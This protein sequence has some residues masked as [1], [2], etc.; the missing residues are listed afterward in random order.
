MNDTYITFQGWVGSDVS[1]H[2]VSEDVRVTSFRVGSTPRRLREG[3]WEDQA[4]A[5]YTV[6]AWRTLGAHVATSVRKGDPVVV[7]GR[8][9]VEEWPGEEG[10]TMSRQVVHALTVGHDLTRG[11][12]RFTKV[13][14][15]GGDGA[16]QGSPEAGAA[17]SE[18]EM[19]ARVT[20]DEDQDQ[21]A[22]RGEPEPVGSVV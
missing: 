8:L 16:R 4:T 15:S 19:H 1:S 6:K 12:T 21:H 3:E 11:E 13:A 18:E 22:E 7:H 9:V 20:T 2:Q 14:R 5:W 10:R 17:T